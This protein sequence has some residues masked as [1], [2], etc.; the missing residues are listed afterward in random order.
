MGRGGAG[1][2]RAKLFFYLCFFLLIRG[3][4]GIL[5]IVCIIHDFF[6]KQLNILLSTQSCLFFPENLVL[7]LLNSCLILTQKNIFNKNDK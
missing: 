3:D 5:Y 7:E 6:Y 4:N 1:R 2:G